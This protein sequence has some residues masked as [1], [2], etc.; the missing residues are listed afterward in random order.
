M[1]C[2][3]WHTDYTDEMDLHGFSVSIRDIR[4]I[5]VLTDPKRSAS[6]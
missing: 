1:P 6:Y 2:C 3:F 5:R 4:V